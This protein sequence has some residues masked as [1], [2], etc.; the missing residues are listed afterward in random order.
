MVH[1]RFNS[2]KTNGQKNKRTYIGSV[3]SSKTKGLKYTTS[4]GTE[5]S[6][7]CKAS[8]YNPGVRCKHRKAFK[9][10]LKNLKR[11]NAKGYVYAGR[12]V[13]G[14]V[15]SSDGK[16]SY[17]TSISFSSDEGSCTCKA[18]FYRPNSQCKHQH[19]IAVKAPD[20][21]DRVQYYGTI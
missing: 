14:A 7:S 2:S 6:C 5:E 15:P 16:K 18:K 3:K 17:V 21:G 13:Y 10:C 9:K 4:V 12:M 19:M 8:Y 20:I 1:I 11:G